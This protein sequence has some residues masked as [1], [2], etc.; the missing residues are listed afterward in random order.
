M[1]SEHEIL[2]M[3][4]VL[5]DLLMDAIRKNDHISTAIIQSKLDVLEFV[6]GESET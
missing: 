5:S 1:R 3:H 4:K 2:I 6:L